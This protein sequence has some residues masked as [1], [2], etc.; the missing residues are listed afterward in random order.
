M[1]ISKEL[2]EIIKKAQEKQTRAYD[3][4][5]EVIR[6]E[7]G[8]A[9]VHIPGG[10]DETPVQLTIN[11]RPGDQVQVRVANG[12]AF[13]M[14]NGTAPP[15]DDKRALQA[16]AEAY[17]ARKVAEEAAAE[18]AGVVNYFWHDANGAHITEVPREEF[19]KDPYDAGGNLL[20][21]STGI[22]IR[23]GMTPVATFEEDSITLGRNS[24]GHGHVTFT[25]DSIMFYP[26]WGDSDFNYGRQVNV[27]VE[28]IHIGDG[29]TRNFIICYFAREPIT[30]TIDGVETTDFDAPFPNNSGVGSIMFNTAPADGA[31]IKFSYTS[32][33]SQP[34]YSFG[35]NRISAPYG[36]AEGCGNTVDGVFS[37]AEGNACKT[38][39][40][41]SHA[42][43]EGTIAAGEAQ[44]AIGKYNIE[45]Q[46]NEYALL[47]GNG[48]RTTRSNALAVTW[49]GDILLANDT[50]ISN[51]LQTLGWTI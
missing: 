49:D 5:A 31:V 22:L 6:V 32:T 33:W 28:Q 10:V 2:V 15:T 42:Q 17:A 45:D 8:V 48:S 26:N 38:S 50:A 36:Y 34:F 20:A 25:D 39:G 27:P 35:V 1:N 9:W 19:L 51:A 11:A 29:E 40:A 7:D 43:N 24:F 3:T 46:N 14:G 47:I 13:L 23:K 21:R 18:T 44:T 16:S 4:K 37:H 30:V 12:S 41:F